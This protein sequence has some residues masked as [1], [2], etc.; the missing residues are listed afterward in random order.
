M[1]PSHT[2]NADHSCRGYWSTT[3]PSQRLVFAL[4]VVKGLDGLFHLWQVEIRRPFFQKTN[5]S[6]LVWPENT[7]P[8]PFD[9]SQMTSG[10]ENSVLFMC[11]MKCLPLCKI[12]FQVAFLDAAA[13]CVEWK[14]FSEVLPRRCGYVHHG[15]MTVSQTIPPKGS[16]VMCIQQ[17]ALASTHQDFPW[18]PEYCHEIMNGE[19]CNR[20][21]RKIVFELTD[22]SL[23][24]WHK[25]VNHNSSLLAMTKPLVDGPFISLDALTC[26]QLNC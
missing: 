17:R 24:V 25:V 23:E 12:Q 4:Y 3:I 26:C 14:W 16:M 6:G 9:P 7:F 22:N 1:V 2:V 18:L 5:L 21:L 13:D 20:V 10:P 11:K 15:S 8:L 19:W